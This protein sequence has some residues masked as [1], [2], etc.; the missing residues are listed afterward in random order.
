MQD[1]KIISGGQVGVDRFALDWAIKNSVPHGGWCPKDR[2]S[3]DGVIPACYNLQE[4]VSQSCKIS[5][6]KNVSYSD[7]TLILTPSRELSGGSLLTRN[8]CIKHGRPYLHLC[9]GDSWQ[10]QIGGF[11]K[12]HWIEVLNVAGTREAAN[13]EQFVYDVSDEVLHVWR[14]VV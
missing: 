5:T 1:F 11:I 6:R 14:K 7:G 10:K 12:N 3:E 13:I 8:Y 4:T 2:C 9:P